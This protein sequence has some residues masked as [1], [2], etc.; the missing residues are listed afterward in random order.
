MKRINIVLYAILFLEVFTNED[1]AV[2]NQDF[3]EC[4][5]PNY[6]PSQI[7]IQKCTEITPY[8]SGT[9]MYKAQCCKITANW[10][11]LIPFKTAYQEN[12]KTMACQ[13]YGID[14]SFSD[15]QLR[16]AV[17]A[18]QPN[19][20]CEI[21]RDYN[22]RTAL[23]SSALLTM[24]KKIVYNCGNGDE[25]FYA[26]YF[27]PNSDL[28]A[29]DKDIADCNNMNENYI[30]KNCYKQ[31]NKL[32]SDRT[33]CCWCETTYFNQ[34]LS[35][36]NSKVCMGSN[37]D[38][39]EESLINMKNAYIPSGLQMKYVCR[40]TNKYGQV[41]NGGFDTSTGQVIVNYKK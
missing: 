33:Q 16:K 13:L 6:K 2:Y 31:G 32:L 37:I 25:T 30:E 18:N 20:R 14:P 21:I 34:N 29:L 23:Y 12:W 10:D 35:G 27:V 1:Q 7:T 40:C 38:M 9:G 39:F 22:K 17:F 24:D 36:K 28:E 5:K 4:N 19:E 8:L 3:L 26:D 11:P 41:I 15:D